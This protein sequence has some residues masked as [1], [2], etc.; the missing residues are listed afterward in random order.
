MSAVNLVYKIASATLLANCILLHAYSP[1]TATVLSCAST[2]QKLQVA[3]L[4]SWP[5]ITNNWGRKSLKS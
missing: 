3:Y 1:R 4:T 5:N 2:K